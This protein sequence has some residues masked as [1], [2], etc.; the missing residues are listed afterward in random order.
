[1]MK[2]KDRNSRDTRWLYRLEAETLRYNSFANQDRPMAFLKSLADKVWAAEAP[3]G[4]R[5]PTITADDGA[6]YRGRAMSYCWDSPR[7]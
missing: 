2:A 1:M 7:S 6:L 3:A 4:R 5:K